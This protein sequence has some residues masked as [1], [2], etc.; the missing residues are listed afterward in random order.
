VALIFCECLPILPRRGSLSLR[1]QW[2]PVTIL[3]PRHY[4]CV[5]CYGNRDLYATRKNTQPLG[6]VCWL[7]AY[8]HFY[9]YWVGVVGNMYQY[10]NILCISS[11]SNSCSSWNKRLI[12]LKVFYS[13]GFSGIIFCIDVITTEVS[14]L[15]SLPLPI[16]S[17]HLPARPL[18]RTSMRLIGDGHTDALLPFFLLSPYRCLVSYNTIG[19]GQR[20]RASYTNS[21]AVT[22]L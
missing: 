10:R 8:D 7:P 4:C 20:R 3:D 1:D 17:L 22:E 19:I 2:L 12:S 13:V 5:Q 16:S 9:Y 14:P 6:P 11:N 15:H 18:R 21:S